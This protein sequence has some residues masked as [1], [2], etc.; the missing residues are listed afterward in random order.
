M[1]FKNKVGYGAGGRKIKAGG[2]KK[3]MMD[4]AS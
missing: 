3:K 1:V 4:P 2:K